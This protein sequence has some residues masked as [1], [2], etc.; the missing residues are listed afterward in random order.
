MS[1]GGDIFYYGSPSPGI[2]PLYCMIGRGEGTNP[3]GRGIISLPSQSMLVYSSRYSPSG[4]YYWTKTGS[5]YDTNFLYKSLYYEFPQ[6]ARINFVRVYFKTLTSGADD[7]IKIESDYGDI[8]TTLGSIS[9]S[10]DGAIEHKRFNK[11][12]PCH[13]FRVVIDTDEANAT[14]GIQYAK[15][16][17]DYDLIDSAD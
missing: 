16:V 3:N 17:V 15:I 9:Y 7:D 13:N 12:I 8:T 2:P 11:M 5:G 1:T 14:T 10:N 6:K 4:A